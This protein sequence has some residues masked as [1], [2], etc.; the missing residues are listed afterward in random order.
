MFTCD[1]RKMFCCKIRSDGSSRRQSL[2]V[3]EPK[4]FPKLLKQWGVHRHLGIRLVTFLNA[5][6]KTVFPI[7]EVSLS[8]VY[9]G[10]VQ[11]AV[12]FMAF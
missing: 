7:L 6:I 4:V 10:R 5:F 1:A 8:I 9:V 11:T 12:Y 2:Q 3:S